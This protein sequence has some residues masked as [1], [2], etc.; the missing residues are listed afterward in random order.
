MLVSVLFFNY[1]IAMFDILCVELL[2]VVLLL[3][4]EIRP[5]FMEQDV[6]STEKDSIA[7]FPL[8]T[9]II[10]LV[11]LINFGFQISLLFLFVLS[12]FVFFTNIKYFFALCTRLTRGSF[13]LL[14][15]VFCFL[16]L[17]ITIAFI[18]IT[19]I[20]FPAGS[21]NSFSTKSHVK[22]SVEKKSLSPLDKNSVRKTSFKAVD[23]KTDTEIDEKELVDKKTIVFIPDVYT[24]SID[25][26]LTLSALALQGF[27]VIAFDVNSQDFRIFDSFL[28]SYSIRSFAVRMALFQNPEF[29]SQ[30]KIKLLRV[31]KFELKV[32]LD[33]IEQ[34][35]SFYLLVDGPIMKEAV[36]SLNTEQ[37]EKIK[38]IYYMNNVEDLI[39]GYVDGFGDL[40]LLCPL[41]Y[42]L[43]GYPKSKDK[44]LPEIVAYKVSKNFSETEEGSTTNDIE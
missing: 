11:S 31:K 10:S 26:Y 13:S 39:Y 22:V 21:S 8:L 20:F 24:K 40:P 14:F 43:L 36:D 30:N 16:E 33:A 19:I 29:I 5:F 42:A 28:D 23:V 32:S 3:I 44:L 37:R 34:N 12:V 18:V 7:F 2:V 38:G 1:H 35:K 4:T 27:E 17:L 9:S 25:S 6:Q 15:K 41:D